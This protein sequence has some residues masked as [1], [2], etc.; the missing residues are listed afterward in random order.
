MILIRS[1]RNCIV[2]F[3]SL[4]MICDGRSPTAILKRKRQGSNHSLIFCFKVKNYKKN[5]IYKGW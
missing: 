5:I 4:I 1:S 3:L 2:I